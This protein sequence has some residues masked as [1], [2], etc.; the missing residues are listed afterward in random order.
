M[1]EFV[2][3]GVTENKLPSH[4]KVAIIGGGVVGCSILYHL[5]KFGWK[6]LLPCI[7]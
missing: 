4:T 6:G 3:E 5:C 1:P 7:E 2:K